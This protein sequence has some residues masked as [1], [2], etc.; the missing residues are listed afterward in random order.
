MIKG[1]TSTGFKF[2]IDERALQN[3]E[4]IEVLADVDD[5]PLLVPKLVKMLL[6]KQSENLKEHI[7][8]TDGYVPTEKMVEEIAEI[9]KSS[10]N[11]KN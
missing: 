11:L 10:Q 7:K 2:E 1:E 3:Y 9:F 5:N 4:L 6:G 8:D